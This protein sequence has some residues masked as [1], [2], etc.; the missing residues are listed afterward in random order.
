MT[1]F[2][3]IALASP[4]VIGAAAITLM[5]ASPADAQSY[6]DR[7]NNTGRDAIVGAVVGGLAGALIGQGDGSYIAG[8]AL[9]GAALGAVSS[10]SNNADCGYNRG[11]YCYRN[12]GHWESQRGIS[13]DPRWEQRRDYREHRYDRRD[14]R[15]DNRDY[16]YDRRW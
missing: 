1:L 8:G 12:Q 2:S 11:G 4:A 9:A 15:R 5:S 16:R 13:R 14:N 7:D 10:N 6:R 3:K